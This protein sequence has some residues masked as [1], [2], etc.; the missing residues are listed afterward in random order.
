MQNQPRRQLHL[1]GT[2]RIKDGRHTIDQFRSHRAVALLIY[3][4]SQ[5]HPVPRSELIELIWPDKPK[6]R[7]Q[8]N[9]RWALSYWNKLLPGC[10]DVTRQTAQFRPTA[11]EVDV[12]VL[13]TA[14]A[15]DDVAGLETSIFAVQDEF[16][17]G[18]YFDESPEFE[19]WLLTRREHWR[20]ALRIAWQRL[21]DQYSSERLYERALVF[22]RRALALDTWQ[23]SEHRQVMLLLARTGDFD[24]AWAQFESC[25]RILADELQIDPTRATCELA[26]RIR[27]LCDRPRHNLP[28]QPT[29]F[30]GREAGLAAVAKLLAAPDNRLV[31][32]VAPGGMGKT[33]LALAAAAAQT[34]VFLEGV[35]FVP[36]APV[37]SPALLAT[38]IVEALS[39]GG[40]IEP[41]QGHKSAAD[42][43]LDV[44]AD[45]E[46][47]LLLDNYE[48]LL[49]DISLI[50]DILAR[51]PQVKLLVTSRERLHTRW[52]RPFPVSG[53]PYPQQADVPDWQQ[54]SAPRLFLQAVRQI[55]PGF[56][57]TPADR[58]A[59]TQICRLVEGMPLALELAATW[60]RVQTPAAIAAEIADN[61]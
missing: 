57:P 34:G 50:L 19:T 56:Q 3:L 20:Q 23:E 42:Y 9:L 16:C 26:D 27:V 53:L 59:I 44:L 52:E 46:L 48:Q 38:T 2:V 47:L 8:A 10:W 17:R 21:I 54:Y 12:L 61:L 31:T 7:G 32:V 49:P 51:A 43:L 40:F 13:Q 24:A 35:A 36:L 22:A 58:V 45:M 11:C 4:V 39:S 55:E 37:E 28:L 6:E 25:R 15:V 30:V 18:F 14:L 33:R 1:L 29:R 41:H 60:V 5:A